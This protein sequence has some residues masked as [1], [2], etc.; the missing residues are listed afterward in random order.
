M[1][2][3]RA[4]ATVTLPDSLTT[5]RIMAVAADRRSRFGSGEREIRATKPVTLLPAFPRFMSVSDPHRSR[6]WSP[7]RW[8][9]TG[10][11]VVT[12][13]SLDPQVLQFCRRTDAHVRDRAGRQRA[14]AFRRER[15]EDG[16][17]R[18]QMTVTIGS[19]TD[20]FELTVPVTA[21][22]EIETT[23]ALRRHHVAVRQKHPAAPRVLPG[24]AASVSRCASTALVGSDRSA[25]YLDE[26]PYECA[27]PKASRALALMLASD[28]NGAFGIAGASP[29]EQRA[30][31]A[32]ALD[33]LGRIPMS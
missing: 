26:Y 7:A 8:R 10:N 28:L 32:R 24:S 23:A 31:A 12:I 5:Y 33:E 13:R 27:E 30:A 19:E 2:A 3:G 18:V 20:A 11:A 1:P 22:T 16:R 9:R 6:P 29:A 4:S 14:G 21:A 15:D 17:A 25:K